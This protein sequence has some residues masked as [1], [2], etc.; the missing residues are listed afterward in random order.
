M[1]TWVCVI[2]TGP[3][4]VQA[5]YE[6]VPRIGDEVVVAHTAYV[7]T[8]VRHRPAAVGTGWHGPTVDLHVAPMSP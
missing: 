4:Q 3:G 2:G 5:E 6:T 7:V 1:S 8:R